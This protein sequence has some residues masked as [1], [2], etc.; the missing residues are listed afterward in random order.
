MLF[1][2]T[3]EESAVVG[4]GAKFFA[5]ILDDQS[6][7]RQKLLGLL[8]VLFIVFSIVAFPMVKDLL[9]H[10][11]QHASAQALHIDETLAGILVGLITSLP[12]LGKLLYRPCTDC[13]MS[14]D[15][16]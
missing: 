14:G 11:L 6:T 15:D 8:K 7:Q 5:M 13:C 1:L 12:Q 10:Y 9:S 16:E 3:N 2:T 4:A